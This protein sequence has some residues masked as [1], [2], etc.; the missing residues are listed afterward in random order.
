MSAFYQDLR[1]GL[2]GL[3][4][5]PALSLIAILSLALGIGANTAIFSVVNTALLNPLPGVKEPRQL[6]RVVGGDPS[7]GKNQYPLSPADFLDI[8]QGGGGVFESIAA[9]DRGIYNLTDRGEPETL[10]GWQIQAEYFKILGIQPQL[11]RIFTP[12]EHEPGGKFVALLSHKVWQRRFGGDPNIVGEKIRINGESYE[13]VGVMPPGFNHPLAQTELWTPLALSQAE[14]SDRSRRIMLGTARLKPGITAAQ[15]QTLLKPIGERWQREFRA[16]HKN[17]GVP[18]Y[19][20]IEDATK[21]VRPALLTVFF[22][23]GFVL[24]IACANVSNLL[25]T[26]G[27]ARRSETAIRS[28][29]G[30]GRPRLIRMFL[31]E[32]VML[33]VVGGL[34]SLPLAYGAVKFLVGLFPKMTTAVHIPRVERVPFDLWVFGFAFL[35]SVL[36]GLLFGLI[37]ALQ[38][39]KTNLLDALKDGRSGKGVGSGFKRRFRAGSLIVIFE[40]ALA[41]LLLSGAGV[42]IKSFTRLTGIDPGFDFER[43]LTARVSLLNNKRY[44]SEEPRRNL[45]RGIISGLETIPG[46][47]GVGL[48]TILPAN[49]GGN[50]TQITF[51]GKETKVDVPPRVYLIAI[52]PGYFKTLG[53]SLLKGRFFTENDNQNSHAVVIINRSLALRYYPNEDPL[54]KY[55]KLSQGASSSRREFGQR[56]IVGVIDDLKNDGLDKESH[57]EVYS[58]YFQE[59]LERFYILLRTKSDPMSYERAARRIVSEQD[60]EMPI[61]MV[62]SLEQ[63]VGEALAPRRIATVMLGIYSAIAFILAAIGIYGVLTHATSQRAHEMG[64]RLALGARPKDLLRMVIRQGMFLVLIGL[65]LGV[66][67]AFALTRLITSQLYQ[68]S[69]TDPASFA[70]ATVLLAVIALTACLFPALRA[71]RGDPIKDLREE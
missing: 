4:K 15:A 49:G 65:G 56:E 16:T 6:V 26:R 52:S 70:L 66:V 41:L 62:T 9:F 47:E 34:L 28:A 48:S 67:L 69:P 25:L 71:T 68:V 2:Q 22:A 54:G 37:P 1:Y 61:S 23:V 42:M 44:E 18:L 20:L 39:S 31:T 14:W 40:V 59:P 46:V 45:A 19:S 17:W 55:I 8:K 27:V 57:P 30:A 5:Q 38:A 50:Y 21:N 63:L 3:M 13:V 35:I 24:L 64:I 58:P 12:E 33:S 51:V 32:S 11:G 29:L 36:C 60:K 53:A 10:T 43:V 7:D